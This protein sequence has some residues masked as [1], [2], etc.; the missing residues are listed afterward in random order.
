MDVS[1]TNQV[2]ITVE[3]QATAELAKL[4]SDR[5]RPETD[6]FEEF[7]SR[8]FITETSDIGSDF[9]QFKHG[10]WAHEVTPAHSCPTCDLLNA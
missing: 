1:R 2:S 5:K 4:E 8:M 9:P 7:K 6:K 10:K 3:E